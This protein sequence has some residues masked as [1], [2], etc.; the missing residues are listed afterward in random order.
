MMKKSRLYPSPF[1]RSMLAISAALFAVIATCYAQ[2]R[3][4]RPVLMHMHVD[5]G[6][7][8][9][10]RTG[11]LYFAS[12][13]EACH[14]IQGTRLVELAGM[15]HLGRAQI[16]ANLDTGKTSY[17]QPVVSAMPAGIA[18]KFFGKTQP[19]DL[20][21]IAKRHAPD[22]LYTYLNSFYL[23]PSRPTGANNVVFHNVSMPDVL[24]T[25]QGLQA[26]IRKMGYRYG[27]KTLVAAGVKPV[28]AGAMSPQQFHAMTRDIVT[29]LYAVAHPH[30]QQRQAI[31]NWVLI[32]LAVLT[33]LSFLLY[34]TYWR[35]VV[36]PQGGRWW[37]YRRQ[38]TPSAGAGRGESTPA[39]RGSWGRR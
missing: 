16:L 25:F 10:L 6:D 35:R 19:P 2:V 15:L 26:P 30:Q 7:R 4:T 18:R 34:K 23:D 8:A 39:N 21:V 29:F 11:A 36:P 17:F 12:Q 14:S 13:C 32:G 33:V 24:A 5:L 28:A 9:A 37:T 20:T 38:D 31:G 1:V 22:W 27:K 3:M